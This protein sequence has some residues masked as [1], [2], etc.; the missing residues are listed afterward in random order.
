MKIP[1]SSPRNRLLSHL[2][3]ATVVTLMSAAAAT[4]FVAI[5][6]ASPTLA[7]S[8]DQLRAIS[9]FR[10]DRDQL[11]GNKRTLPGLDRDHGPLLAALED[12]AHRAYPAKDVPMSATLNAIASF[13]Q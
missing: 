4:A 13:T 8:Q 11:G 9:K 3:I 12:Y 5:K 1:R 2:R 10:G 6:P 7:S